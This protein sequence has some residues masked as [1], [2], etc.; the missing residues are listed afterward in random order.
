MIRSSAHPQIP[1]LL[2]SFDFA[3]A[4]IVDDYIDRIATT[5]NV[6]AHP[7]CGRYMVPTDDSEGESNPREFL[8]LPILDGLAYADSGEA[9]RQATSLRHAP[10]EVLDAVASVGKNAACTMKR[11][12]EEI[13]R[14]YHQSAMFP[15]FTHEI[16]VQL[17]AHILTEVTSQQ[18]SP[19][20]TPPF[21][22]AEAIDLLSTLSEGYVNR[23]LIDAYTVAL[24]SDRLMLEAADIEC[25]RRIRGERP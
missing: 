21:F 17:C 10:T 13:E 18:L 14:E 1:F 23:L 16:M 9:I 4:A 25:A 19:G 24:H 11:R 2:T 20:S 3:N 15:V 22:T 12:V 7:L 6:I 8:F 5:G